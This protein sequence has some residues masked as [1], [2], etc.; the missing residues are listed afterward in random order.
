MNTII[1]IDFTMN[2][3][4]GNIIVNRGNGA[5]YLFIL[6]ARYSHMLIHTMYITYS[7]NA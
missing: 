1:L 4:C 3:L 7:V 6:Y 2:V 5:S